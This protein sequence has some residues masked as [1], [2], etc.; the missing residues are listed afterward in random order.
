M[1]TNIRDYLFAYTNTNSDIGVYNKQELSEI[2]TKLDTDYGEGSYV[3]TT[4]ENGFIFAELY[5]KD[6]AA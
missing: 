2:A 4:R 1:S 3:D 6:R 5:G